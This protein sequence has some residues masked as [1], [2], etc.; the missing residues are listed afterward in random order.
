MYDALNEDPQGF[1]LTASIKDLPEKVGFRI[2]KYLGITKEEQFS[3]TN[4]YDALNTWIRI[5]EKSGILVNQ[6]S[7]IEVSVVRGF[8]ISEN[9][10]PTISLN[11]KD[12]PYGR[13]FTLL[14]E[15][16]HL[17]LG[18]GGLC[19]L[20]E[21]EGSLEVYCNA[22]A[23]EALVPSHLLLRH[24]K[25]VDNPDEPDWSD[26]RLQALSNCFRV[27]REVI[28]RR[29]LTLGKTT[30]SIYQKRREIFQEEYKELRKGE[31]GYMRYHKRILRNNGIAYTSLLLNAYHQRAITA[32]DVSRYLGDMRLNHLDSIQYELTR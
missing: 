11:G 2:R 9:P 14:H 13:I 21:D 12:A 5:A 7:G 28:L 27:S 32:I 3:W 16:C 4:P 8:S 1:K 15:I 23:A 24:P 22:A 26:N 31:G 18:M 25:V 17:T 20:H 19:D 10:L 30:V 6:F 29:L